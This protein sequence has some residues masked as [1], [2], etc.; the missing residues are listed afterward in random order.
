MRA[1]SRWGRTRKCLRLRYRTREMRSSRRSACRRRT[2]W[3]NSTVRYRKAGCRTWDCRLEPHRELSSTRCRCNPHRLQPLRPRRPAADTP[4]SYT[5]RS[6]RPRNNKYCSHR[7]VDAGCSVG[8]RDR[9]PDRR[10]RRRARLSRGGRRSPFRRSRR[11]LRY[12]RPSRPSAP[13]CH[14]R[15]R[16]GRRLRHG[17]SK[18]YPSSCMPRR[19]AAPRPSSRNFE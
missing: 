3:R 10:R 12:F 16:L 18:M 11:P 7:P 8:I 19:P 9:S 6:R 4:S 13:N 15:R 14:R 17:D 2:G 5:A 1:C